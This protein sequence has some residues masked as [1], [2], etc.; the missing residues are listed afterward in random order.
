MTPLLWHRFVRDAREA[1]TALMAVGR[2]IMPQMC[3]LVGGDIRPFALKWG[4][5]G[6]WGVHRAG[7]GSRHRRG[8]STAT[9][10]R[11]PLR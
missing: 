9:T 2:V 1:H 4:V 11:K 7:Q 8:C 10:R 5:G 6:S 3:L